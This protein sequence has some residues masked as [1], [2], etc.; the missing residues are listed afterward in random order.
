MEDPTRELCEELRPAA[1]GYSILPVA[2]RSNKIADFTV[3]EDLGIH[4]IQ[5][6]ITDESLN[7]RAGKQNAYRWE[8]QYFQ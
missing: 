6:H 2:G 1:R 3:V 5:V 7:L 4:F 8:Q